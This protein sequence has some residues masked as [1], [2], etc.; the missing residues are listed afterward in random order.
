MPGFSLSALVRALLVWL[1]IVAAESAQGALRQLLFGPEVQ[2]LV[3]QISVLTGS[4]I[5]FALAWG[6]R[7]WTRTST[8]SGAMA[9][10]VLWVVLTVAFEIALGRAT[11]LGWGRIASD[12]DL[13]HGGM[14]PLGL[15]SLGLTPWAVSGLETRRLLRLNQRH[16]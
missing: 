9:T 11:G 3:R 12:Y 6:C 8:V 7:R 13:M 2:F 15:L 4:I 16:A 10:G 1:L 14:M 5:I